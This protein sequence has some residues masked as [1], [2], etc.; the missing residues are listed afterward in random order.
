MRSLSLT[1]SLFLLSTVALSADPSVGYDSFTVQAGHRTAPLAA[2][3]WSPVGRETYVGEV[4]GNAV[5]TPVKAYIGA[6]LPDEKM[7]LVVLSHGS[8]GSMG[9]MAWLGAGI[10]EKGALVVV[11]NHPGTTSGDSSPRR[12]TRLSERAADL[13][14]VLDHVLDDPYF[15]SRVDTSKVT[16]MGFSLGG[17]TVLGIGG[18]RLNAQAYK[19]YCETYRDEAQDCIFLERGGVDFDAL[20][21]EFVADMSDE[22]FSSIVAIDPGFTHAA[23]YESLSRVDR[24]VQ[25]VSLGQ[26]FPWVAVDVRETG[27]GLISGLPNAD[28]EIIPD[29]D[30]FSFLPICTDIAAQL[31]IEAGEDPICDDPYGSDRAAVH[32]ASIDAITNFLGL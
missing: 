17:A 23:T 20:P 15:G 27:S 9:S 19:T 11:L 14:A 18:V 3:I 7:P 2:G 5:F 8:G 22:R 12:T 13:S 16:A 31:L 6:A 28:H 1:S 4:G 24:P 29:A 30:H 32:A 21:H 25:I 26:D 10:A